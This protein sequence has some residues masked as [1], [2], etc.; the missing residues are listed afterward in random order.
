MSCFIF[1]ICTISYVITK[2]VNFCS[3][4]YGDL[5]CYLSTENYILCISLKWIKSSCLNLFCRE[6][7]QSDLRL[8]IRGD[9]LW[10]GLSR[11]QWRVPLPGDQLVRHGRDPS[12]HQDQ[13][14]AWHHLRLATAQGHEEYRDDQRP[15]GRVASVS[16]FDW[17]ILI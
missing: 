13:R 12:H 16:V 9:E 1:A 8:W 11:R 4:T 10:L 2:M 3:T 6:Q 15:G 7:I 5:L 14:Q 17:F